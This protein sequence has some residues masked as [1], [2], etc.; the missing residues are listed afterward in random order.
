MTSDEPKTKP[1]S[2]KRWSQR[3]LESAGAGPSEPAAAAA[4]PAALPS[5]Q[6]AAPVPVP[7]APTAD[8]APLPPLES[9]TIDS[10]FTR[11]M[12]P[13]VDAQLKRHALKQL[14]RDPRFNVMDGLDVYIDDYSQPDPISPEVVRKMVQGRYIFDPP[15]TR[16]NEQGMVEDVP[17]EEVGANAAADESTGA[18]ALSEASTPGPVA[19]SAALAAPEGS[20]APESPSARPQEPE[21][22]PR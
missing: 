6:H 21:P 10:D 14:F 9:L 7:T 13:K 22:A 17:P 12:G 4:P 20:T 8:V 19:G 2:L 5:D 3:K 18:E 15:K 16:V 1:F 11:F